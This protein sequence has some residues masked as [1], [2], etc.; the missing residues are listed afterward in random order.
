MTPKFIDGPIPRYVQLADLMRQ[1]IA[2]GIWPEGHK[3]PSLEELVAEFGVARA[4]VRHGIGLLADEGLVARRQGQGTF[5]TG[6]P[7]NDRWIKVVTSLA[8]LA[9]SYE[10]T[11]PTIVN[12]DESTR[13][14][15]IQ[16]HEGTPAQRYVYMRRVHSRD[17]RAYCVIDIYLDEDIFRKHPKRFRDE[18]VIPLLASM[19]PPVVAQAHQILTIGTADMELA[20]LLDI[21]INAPVAE[22]RRV[23]RNRQG[24]IIY[25]AQVTYRGDAIHLKMDLVT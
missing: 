17:G 4:T 24:T 1:R 16:P 8:E 14:P 7:Q 23:F 11:R 25:L 21:P 19:K 18:T 20:R 5:V 15:S 2:R 6:R 12:I 13:L 3:L 9:K 22:V 10:D